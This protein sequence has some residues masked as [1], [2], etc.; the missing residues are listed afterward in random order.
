[1][2]FKSL[3]GQVAR[4]LR[5]K[6]KIKSGKVSKKRYSRVIPLPSYILSGKMEKTTS[7]KNFIKVANAIP[8][9][10]SAIAYLRAFQGGQN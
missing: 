4:V 3:K 8:R 6:S 7:L 5:S 2:I 10:I 1:V 9:I